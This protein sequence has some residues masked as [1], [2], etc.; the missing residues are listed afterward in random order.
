MK[1][2]YRFMA[3]DL[4]TFVIEAV[5]RYEHFHIEI[6]SSFHNFLLYNII[7]CAIK[8]VRNFFLLLL[9]LLF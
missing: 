8:I 3:I 4:S 2:L 1:Q 9:I 6:S 5:E 7:I